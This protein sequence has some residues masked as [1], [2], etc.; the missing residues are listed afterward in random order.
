[1]PLSA[2]RVSAEI[3]SPSSVRTISPDQRAT[4]PAHLRCSSRTPAGRWRASAQAQCR[5][6]LA[7]PAVTQETARSP[8]AP[9]TRAARGASSA[10]RPRSASRRWR[11]C[12]RCRTPRRT[13]RPARAQSWS[14]AAAHVRGGPGDAR[15]ASSEHVERTVHRGV[16]RA[17][18]LRDLGGV[19][20]EHLAEHENRPLAR[21][22]MLERGHERKRDRL[23]GVVAGCGRAAVEIR[24]AS[25]PGRARARAAPGSRVGSGR[26]AAAP[27][28]L[29]AP[30]AIA[31]RVQAAIGGYPVKPGA[32]GRAPSNWSIPRHAANMVS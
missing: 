14:A 21:R 4:G 2:N 28:P 9:G 8:P 15:R 5:R 6:V 29:G 13:A 1:M 3:L 23:L 26:S 17:E 24:R 30:A 19:E 11:R 10:G 18:H 7:D 16:V 12:C 20:A 22:E 31:E 27:A 32:H 25:H